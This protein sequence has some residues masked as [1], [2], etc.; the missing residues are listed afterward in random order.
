[1]KCIIL[2]AGYAT[3]LYPLTL[4]T[5]KSLLPV[6]KVP[7][8]SHII[9]KLHNVP[10]I[11]EVFVVTNDKFYSSFV[12][13]LEN[14]DDKLKEKIEIINDCTTSN[15]NRLGGIRDLNFVIESKNI[16][17]DVLV[18]LG[19]NYF[20]FNLGNFVNFFK[21][22]R[23]TSLGV[24]AVDKEQAKRFG[25]IEIED[26]K[27]ISFEE[28]PEEPKSNLVSTGVYIFSKED[29]EEI[30]E[31]MKSDLNKDGPGYLIKYLVNKKNVYAYKFEGWWFDI[32]NLEEYEKLK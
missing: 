5:P 21:E 7:L 8:L 2:C 6:R 17:E 12:W 28:K 13:W 27:I 20:N 23:D 19:D 30:N 31:Y 11:D 24:F 1:M 22:T 4:N 18:I 9:E 16:K 25:V 3:R 10:D 32:G 15:E 14:L 26:N 29:L